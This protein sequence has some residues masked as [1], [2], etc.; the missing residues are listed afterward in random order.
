MKNCQSTW[1][2]IICLQSGIFGNI[3]RKQNYRPASIGMFYCSIHCIYVYTNVIVSI[4]P[5]DDIFYLLGLLVNLIS[6]CFVKCKLHIDNIQFFLLLWSIVLLAN[7][8]IITSYPGIARTSSLMESFK[9]VSVKHKIS[10]SNK[11]KIEHSLFLILLILRW[12][13]VR[14][15]YIV[16]QRLY[17]G[18]S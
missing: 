16:S 13:I 14:W 9:C 17:Q 10:W 1:N 11:Y 4:S 2:R 15:H 8:V 18:W 6:T 7:D 3:V 5:I 12:K